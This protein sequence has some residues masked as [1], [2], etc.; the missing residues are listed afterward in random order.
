LANA[1][2]LITINTR[3]GITQSILL[4]EPYSP[5]PE[6]VIAL[7]TGGAGNVGMGV[8]DG[9]AEAARPYLFSR[10]REL[11]SQPQFAVAIIDTPSDRKG[12]SEEFRQSADHVTDMEHVVAEIRRR[13]PDARL[14]VMG[15]SRGTVSAG[16]ISRALEGRVAAT[17]LFSGRYHPT[18]RAADAP[19]EAPGG[20]GLSALDLGALK[21]PVLLVHHSKDAC[22]ATPFAQANQLSARVPLIKVDGI[23]EK[24]SE[25][26][27]ASG[28]NHWLAGLEKAAGEEVVKWL[29]GKSWLRE[30]R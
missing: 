15:H 8:K 22:G 7:F 5:K 12:M 1:D 21:N 30:L 17:V 20:S 2:E 25:T 27:C 29:T 28:T 10:Q 26:P 16:Y 4:W 11:F 6:F 24:P 9:R 14:V 23:D 3:S 13:F 18:P 19:P